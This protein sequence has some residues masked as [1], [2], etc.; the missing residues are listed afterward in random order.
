MLKYVIERS[1]TER[2]TVDGHNDDDDDVGEN[3][4]IIGPSSLQIHSL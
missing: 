3:E 1:N 4:T 2:K